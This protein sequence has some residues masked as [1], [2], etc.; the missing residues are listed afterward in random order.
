MAQTQVTVTIESLAPENGVFL[1]P[2]W[3]G[4]HN[5]NFDTYDRGTAISPA[6]ERLVE[7]GNTAPLSQEF[8]DSGNG[9]V[10]GTIVGLDGIE[11][12]ID[13]GEV[14]TQT[15]TLES[16]DPTSRY[17]SYASMIIPSNDAFIANGDPL[18]REIFDA[19]GNFLGAE[20]IIAGSQ[21]LDG[22]SEVNDELVENTAFFA[23]AAPDTGVEENGVVTVHPGFIPGGRILSED[24]SSDNA[25]TAFTGAD[26]TAEGYQIARITVSLAEESIVIADP[27]AITS[28]LDGAQ[29]VAEGDPDAIGNSILTLNDAG[30]SLEYSLTISGLDFGANGLIEG[31]SQT[32]DTSDDVTRLHIHN[33]AR[34]ANGDVVFSIFDTVAPDLGNALNIQG[35]QDED[36]AVTLNGDGSVTLTGIWEETDPANTALSEFVDDFRNGQIGEDLPFYWNVHTEEFPGGAIRGQLIVT[37]DE[38][39]DTPFTRFQNSNV[40]GTYI[41]AAGAEADNIRNNFPNFAEEGVAF[42]AAI[43][44]GD[45]LISLFRLESN[46]LPGTFLY[47]GEEEL[48]SIN[49]NPDFSNAFTNQGV[50]FYIYGAG[51]NQEAPFT[52]FQNSNVPG[53]YIYATGAEANNIRNN[54]TSFIDEGIAFEGAI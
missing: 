45:D 26:F 3:V 42:S 30:D 48:N 52:R 7:D 19:D 2:F 40:P 18:I 51:S 8:L 25:P 9:V 4:F 53:T 21:I 27:V 43:A 37:E 29:E 16:T 23:Q 20:F 10:D 5:G 24:G 38:L 12:P 35:N 6:F 28:V 1:T 44:P 34:G 50:A 41:Y 22:G 54:L 14:V 31:G 49:E 11:G 36:L 46:Q 33:A 17:F 13:P 47:V 15:F 32:E 39:L